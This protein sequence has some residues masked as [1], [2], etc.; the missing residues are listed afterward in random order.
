M[1]S[2][3][4][5]DTGTDAPAGHASHSGFAAMQPSLVSERFGRYL[6]VSVAAQQTERKS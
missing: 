5:G 1:T 2:D 3:L 6:S 4:I